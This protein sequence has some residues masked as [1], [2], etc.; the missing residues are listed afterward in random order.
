MVFR[1]K[2]TDELCRASRILKTLE[3]TPT[4]AVADCLEALFV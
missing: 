2:P 4:D 3:M 1:L